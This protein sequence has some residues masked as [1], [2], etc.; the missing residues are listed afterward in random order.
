MTAVIASVLIGG[1]L[2]GVV[3]REVGR[4]SPSFVRLVAMAI[5]VGELPPRF[6]TAEF[7]LGLG[8][9]SGLFLGAGTSLFVVLL[10]AARDAWLERYPPRAGPRTPPDRSSRP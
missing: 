9:V 6:D 3:G 1:V 5:D 10:M 7:G 2:G 4:H 8:V